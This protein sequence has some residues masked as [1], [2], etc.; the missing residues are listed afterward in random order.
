MTRKARV[1][2]VSLGCPKNLVDS[3]V[4]L[5]LLE[6]AGYEIVDETEDAD[7]AIVNTCSFIA[8]AEEEAVDALLDLADLKQ[9]RLKALI[10]AGCLTERHGHELL[11]EFAEVD[12]FVGVGGIPTIAETVARAP[13]ASASSSR[14][15]GTTYTGGTA[16]PAYRALMDVIPEDRGR[17][18]SPVRLLHDP[19][20]PRRL[21]QRAHG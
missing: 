21:P 14:R 8:P 20:N 12:A 15:P 2:L 17:L 11:D 5:G 10:C 19:L 16:A 3:Q 1:A 7:V 4:M 18:R 6:A 9:G 13:P